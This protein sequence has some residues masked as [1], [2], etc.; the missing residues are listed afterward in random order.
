MGYMDVAIP[1]VGGLVCVLLPG[2]LTRSSAPAVTWR[3]R[4]IGF[5]LLGVAALY[6]VIRLSGH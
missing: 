5:G 3:I 2:S 4:K 1:A 6:L